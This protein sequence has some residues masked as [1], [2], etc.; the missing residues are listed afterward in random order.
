MVPLFSLRDIISADTRRDRCE[1]SCTLVS[2]S[3]FLRS[4][5]LLHLPLS[6]YSCTRVEKKSAFSRRHPNFMRE[7]KRICSGPPPPLPLVFYPSSLC[8][9]R[10]GTCVL[11]IIQYGHDDR[12]CAITLHLTF[13]RATRECKVEDCC[14]CSQ[15]RRNKVGVRNKMLI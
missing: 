13:V 15:N 12:H 5:P 2:F 14:I 6:I 11:R 3:L 8:A 7:P 4:L 9:N 1:F 10:L